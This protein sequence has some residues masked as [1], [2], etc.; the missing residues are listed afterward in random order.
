MEF[1][2]RLLPATIKNALTSP[3]YLTAFSHWAGVAGQFDSET[4]QELP[5]T[6]RRMVQLHRDELI[7]S[8]DGPCDYIFTGGTTGDRMIVPVGEAEQAF[9]ERFYAAAIRDADFGSPLRRGLRLKAPFHGHEIVTPVPMRIHPIG[10]YDSGSFEFA[11]EMLASKHEETG[12]E[13]RCTVIAGGERLVRA[14]TLDARAREWSPEQ[15][16]VSLLLTSGQQLTR[17]WRTMYETFWDARV[18]D[19]YGL[20]E[21]YGGA[22][23]D[24]DSGWYFFDPPCFAEVVEAFG[25]RRVRE[26]V[27]EL[28]LTSLYPFQ[29]VFPLIRYR[30]GD[31]VKVTH[32]I[33]EREGCPAIQPLGRIAQ[34]SVVSEHSII[35][36][37]VYYEVLD[38]WEKVARTEIF[39][40]AWQLRDRA[41]LGHPKYKVGTRERADQVEIVVTIQTREEPNST[42]VEEIGNAIRDEYARRMGDVWP[43]KAALRVEFDSVEGPRNPSYAP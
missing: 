11:R 13:A 7:T 36:P 15:A 6:D 14:F 33:P 23:E 42:F 24:L 28:V 40:D 26:G 9:I 30:S 17:K 3:F 31:L 5:I 12:V 39:L 20:A 8:R 21:V 25:S 32:S 1:A 35:P 22:T 34:A 41:L 2:D 19:R 29:Q 37:C 16:T 38:D 18:I 27:G 43:P 10:I 4:I